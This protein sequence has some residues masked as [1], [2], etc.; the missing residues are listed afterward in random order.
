MARTALDLS[1]AVNGP[2]RSVNILANRAQSFGG[3]S[4]EGCHILQFDNFGP[5]PIETPTHSANPH[6]SFPALHNAKDLSVRCINGLKCRTI[7]AKQ[8]CIASPC[9]ERTRPVFIKDTHGGGGPACG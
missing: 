5:Q 9:P 1:V 7:V 8:P 4:V 2:N 3:R 6:R